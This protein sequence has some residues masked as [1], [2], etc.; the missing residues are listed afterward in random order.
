MAQRIRLTTSRNR[1]TDTHC[2]FNESCFRS[3]CA[4][5]GLLHSLTYAV[6]IDSH[7]C[8]IGYRSKSR[9]VP[10]NV[11]E[12][13]G[14]ALNVNQLIQLRPDIESSALSSVLFSL[15]GVLITFSL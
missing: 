15:E 7:H 8:H 9:S 12:K 14:P 11:G 1:Q 2:Q 6:G 3:E 5:E 4:K 13:R 10:M